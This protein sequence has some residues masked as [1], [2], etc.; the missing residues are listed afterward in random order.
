MHICRVS[1]TYLSTQW[2]YFKFVSRHIIHEFTY[3]DTNCKTLNVIRCGTA[4]KLERNSIHTATSSSLL[5]WKDIA[6][7]YC[8]FSCWWWKGKIAPHKHCLGLCWYVAHACSSRWIFQISK[9]S[10][11]IN[12]IYPW[13]EFLPVFFLSCFLLSPSS[14]CLKLIV[15]VNS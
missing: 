15:S 10:N 1:K 7:T 4:V 3:V 2:M 5:Y 6:V 14:R 13:K 9:Y 11:I 12:P 8:W